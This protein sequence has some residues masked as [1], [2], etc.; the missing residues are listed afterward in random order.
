MGRMIVVAIALQDQHRVPESA[1]QG[2][3]TR[4]SRRGALFLRKF[5]GR[6]APTGG[7]LLWLRLTVLSSYSLSDSSFKLSPLIL[8]TDFAAG[9]KLSGRRN[10]QN[11]TFL[12][13][14]R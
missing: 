7:G 1:Y 12:E 4:T 2:G 3:V 9:C 8:A 5:E 13:R 10:D 14:Q 11:T 6:L